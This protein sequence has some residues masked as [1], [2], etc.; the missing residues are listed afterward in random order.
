M[1]D[2]YYAILGVDRSATTEEIKKAFRRVARETHPDANPHDTEAEAKFKRAAEAYEVLS[3]P[4][5][6]RRYDRGDTIDLSD[7]F[8]GVGSLDDLLRS[9]F[10]DSGLFGGRPYR[11]PRGRD[12]MVRTTISLEEAASGA[13][14]VVEYRAHMSCEECAG[15]GARPGSDPIT[16]PDCA[17]AGQVRMAQRSIF[18][19][20]MSVTTC[21]TCGGVGSLIP[22]PCP[23]CGGE[24]ARPETVQVNVEV[25][26]G[27]S[28]GTRLRLSGR[29][30]SGGRA[31]QAGDL[32]VE[33][34]VA[35]DSRFE[36]QDSDLVHRAVIGIAEA[37]LGT[38]I[39]VPSIDG[40][41]IDLEIPAG[42]QPGASFRFAGKGMP[43]LGRRQRG[44]L[45]VIT[46]VTIPESLSEEEADL[47]RSW[48]ELRGERV[49]RPASAG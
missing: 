14:A 45:H 13:E 40:E 31:G 9:V 41:H 38:R 28:S 49:D 44:D 12:V 8:G 15:T 24:G 42:T 20:M 1:A 21:P 7:L 10:G 4:D 36:R 43:H 47:M 26:P 48:A 16:C 29:G 39:D 23:E 11:P 30:E 19:T 3:D 18:G 27:V 33:I 5:R 17:G 37:T 34:D 46:E 32:F 6:R 35:P 2:D 25:P 22:D